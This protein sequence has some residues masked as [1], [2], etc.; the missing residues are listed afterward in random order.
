MS[1][2]NLNGSGSHESSLQKVTPSIVSQSTWAVG[3]QFLIILSGGATSILV[4][5]LLQPEGRGVAG[6]IMLWPPLL[7]SFGAAGWAVSIRWHVSSNNLRGRGIWV[8]MQVWGLLLSLAL[9]AGGYFLLPRLLS[10]DEAFISQ[11]RSYLLFIPIAICST[12]STSVLE[13]M[14]RFDRASIVRIC[15]T[16]LVLL[17]L[18]ALAIWGWVQ[19]ERYAQLTLL[20]LLISALIGGFLAFKHSLGEL[21]PRVKGTFSFAFRAAPLVWAQLVQT[22][23]DQVLVLAICRPSLADFGIYLAATAFAAVIL[24]AATGLASVLVPASARTDPATAMELGLRM[25]RMYILLAI[26]LG[27]PLVI[28]APWV[29]RVAFGSGFEGGAS[30]LRLA[31]L[32]GS[33]CGLFQVYLGLLQGLGR[34]G[35]A[36]AVAVIGSLASIGLAI[37]LLFSIGLAGA[38]WAQILGLTFGLIILCFMLSSDGMILHRVLP[39]AADVKYGMTMIHKIWATRKRGSGTP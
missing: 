6:L 18:V 4:N 8:G 1:G 14:G 15:N 3:T 28:L 24:P 21:G 34:P 11:C 30:Y 17:G 35:R 39:G 36:S 7:A 20:V 10:Q 5:R 33:M 13:G 37:P 38:L 32:Q 9:V 31:V 12:V 2:I 16:L 23:V 29:L 27:G 25:G 26:V 22:R 19:P